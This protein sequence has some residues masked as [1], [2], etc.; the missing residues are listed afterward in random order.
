MPEFVWH[1]RRRDRIGIGKH[2]PK[3]L[4]DFHQYGQALTC[5]ARN[6]GRLAQS[7]L[8]VRIGP[9][10]PIHPATSAHSGP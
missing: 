2:A 7:V 3:G 4:V 8:P 5:A 6:T 1:H 10:S 9:L